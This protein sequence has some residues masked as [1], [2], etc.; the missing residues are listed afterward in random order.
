[1]FRRLALAAGA[2]LLLA[3]GP[4]Q[5]LDDAQRKEVEAI[6]GSYL[7]E[8]PEVILDAIQ[9]LQAKNEAQKVEASR[10]AIVSNKAKIFDDPAS[11]TM[12]NPKGDVTLVEFFDYNCGYC[13]SVQ[14]AVM[15]MVKDDTKLR[16]VFKEFPIL[17]ESSLTTAKA[18]LAAKAQGKYV[19]MHNALMSHRGGF[20]DDVIMKLAQGVGLDTA[21]LKAD[22]E[23]PEIAQTIA[24]DKALAES[25]GIAGTPAFIIGDQLVP[26]A[27]PKEELAKLIAAERAK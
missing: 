17:A 27:V 14:G 21:K 24:A 18:A 6:V 2:A 25:L 26:G 3:A 13:K 16:F 11:P 7:R 10:N 5:A 12:G 19:E 15:Q 1:M 9:A 23:K 8:H 4:A 22:M 20:T